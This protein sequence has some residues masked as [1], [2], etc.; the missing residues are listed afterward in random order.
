MTTT[1]TTPE[2]EETKYNKLIARNG[3]EYIFLESIFKTDTMQGAVGARVIPVSKEHYE[4]EEAHKEYVKVWWQD[5]VANDNTEDSLEDWLA[6]NYDIDQDAR[7]DVVHDDDIVEQMRKHYPNEDATP[8]FEYIGFGR[9]FSPEDEYEQ[10]YDQAVDMLASD[11]IE[12]AR[13]ENG[14]PHD[15][16][17][18]AIRAHTLNTPIILGCTDSFKEGITDTKDLKEQDDYE[19]YVAEA[20]IDYDVCKRIRYLQAKEQN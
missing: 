17:L 10:V 8:I 13:R 16:T 1:T 11:A 20:C 4:D 3:E 2:R 19:H 15:Y 18:E 9:M 14:D 6:G 7:F 5:A 12:L